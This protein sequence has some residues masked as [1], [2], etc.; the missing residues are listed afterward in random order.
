MTC[1]TSS[2]AGL[3][4][5]D[6]HDLQALGSSL[7]AVGSRL[8][9]A[10]VHHIPHPRH[11]HRG[12]SNVGGQD[13]LHST[14]IPMPLSPMMV[15]HTEWQRSINHTVQCLKADISFQIHLL[16]AF[17]R[18]KVFQGCI[19][20]MRF[21]WCCAGLHTSNSWTSKKKRPLRWK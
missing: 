16:S 13:D 1:T 10:C 3:G 5:R 15:L 4:L 11:R 6:R 19:L 20:P 8:H 21:G 2:L 12:L 17:G 9:K 14:A 7:A 18:P